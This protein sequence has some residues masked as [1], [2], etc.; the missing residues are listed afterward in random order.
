M[1]GITLTVGLAIN[2]QGQ[3][4]ADGVD[5][6]GNFTQLLLTPAGESVP[7]PPVYPEA[8]VPEPR[9]PWLC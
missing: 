8:P 1:S 9:P 7:S 6:K 4:L 5:A 2:N 3:I